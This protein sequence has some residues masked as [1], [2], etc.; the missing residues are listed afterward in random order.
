MTPHDDDH[1]ELLADLAH[2]V[3]DLARELR[4]GD[5]SGIA[6]LTGTQVTVLRYLDGHPGARPAAVAE[7]LGLQRSNLSAALRVLQNEG[8]VRR[9]AD[10]EDARVGR[11]HLTDRADENIRRLGVMWSRR[12]AAVA[13]G[14]R[15]DRI[16][17]AADLIDDLARA[18]RSNGADP[19]P[20]PF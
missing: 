13:G 1:D 11:L 16:A 14:R 3:Q 4:R 12:L 5:D 17:D 6:P 20:D 2:A 7:A 8:L 15:R 18:L 19:R 10:P 9:E